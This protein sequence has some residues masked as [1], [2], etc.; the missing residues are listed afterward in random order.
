VDFV[1]GRLFTAFF[2]VKIEI[3][4]RFEILMKVNMMSTIFWNVTPYSLVEIYRV[5]EKHISFIRSVVL[6][7]SLCSYWPA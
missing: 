4:V 2:S 7:C 1:R 5:S 6:S 3:L